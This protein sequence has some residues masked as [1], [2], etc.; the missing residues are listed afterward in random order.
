MDLPEIKVVDLRVFLEKLEK[1]FFT[2][3]YP[4][5]DALS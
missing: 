2:C 4:T 5:Q 1:R 3:H